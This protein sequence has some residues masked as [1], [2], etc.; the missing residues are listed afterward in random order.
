MIDLN[1]GFV[2]E[3]EELNYTLKKKIGVNKKGE[4]T[5]K[6]CGYFGGLKNTI[7]HCVNLIQREKLGIGTF[8]L[9]EA[10]SVLNRSENEF[11]ELLNRAILE[12][13]GNE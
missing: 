4:T 9:E 5:Y 8:N 6:T 7:T 3:V 1:N 13:E 2:V 11:K 10:I 12:L